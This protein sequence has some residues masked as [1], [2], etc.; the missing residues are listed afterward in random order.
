MEMRTCSFSG[1]NLVRRFSLTEF[2][3]VLIGHGVFNDGER[4]SRLEKNVHRVD[5]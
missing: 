3:L 2:D 1:N 5:R 4:I